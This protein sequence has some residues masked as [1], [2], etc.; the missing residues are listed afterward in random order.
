LTI[1]PVSGNDGLINLKL[2][3]KKTLFSLGISDK[4]FIISNSD[5]KFMNATNEMVVLK[6]KSLL[7]NSLNVTG[8][9]LINNIKQ[10]RMIKYD[11]WKE[12]NTDLGWGFNKISVC[13]HY[14]VL[15]GPCLLGQEEISKT[16][17][18]LP[19]HTMVKIEALYH[20]FGDWDAE[21]GYMKLVNSKISDKKEN[22]LWALRCLKEKIPPLFKICEPDICKI[23]SPISVSLSHN[24]RDI[25]IAFGSTIKSNSCTRSYAISDIKIYVR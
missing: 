23:A 15:G 20:F 9:I 21:S 4:S 6:G 13:G 7:T 17:T 1:N 24:D 19:E 25:K 16:F 11:S 2:K 10:W 12:N 3:N 18:N 22:Y 5:Y 8:E 14:K